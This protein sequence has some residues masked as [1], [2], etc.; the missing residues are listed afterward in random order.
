M[1]QTN[2]SSPRPTM[3]RVSPRTEY[4]SSLKSCHSIKAITEKYSL[5]KQ[6]QTDMA[7]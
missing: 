1:K 6:D 4:H 3:G 5:W 7:R 2:T